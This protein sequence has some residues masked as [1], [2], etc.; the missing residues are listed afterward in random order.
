MSQDP[1]QVRLV[2]ADGHIVAMRRISNL[3]SRESA[4]IDVTLPNQAGH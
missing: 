4:H 2:G 3:A 1:F